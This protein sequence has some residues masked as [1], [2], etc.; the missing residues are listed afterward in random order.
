MAPPDHHATAATG[1]SSLLLFVQWPSPNTK[2]LKSKSW[3]MCKV[4]VQLCIV[5]IPINKQ[6]KYPPLL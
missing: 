4:V 5:L 1:T 3:N 2:R 6:L